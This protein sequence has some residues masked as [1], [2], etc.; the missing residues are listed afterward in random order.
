MHNV[1]YEIL[2]FSN[3]WLKWDICYLR[4]ILFILSFE[5]L[6]ILSFLSSTEARHLAFEKI[7]FFN[8]KYLMIFYFRMS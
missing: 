6:I 1:G 5:Y 4:K 8:F 7:P 2:I 3:P